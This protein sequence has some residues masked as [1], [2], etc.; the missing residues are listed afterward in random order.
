MDEDYIVILGNI[1]PRKSHLELAKAVDYINNSLNKAVNLVIVGSPIHKTT[2]ITKDIKKILGSRVIFTGYLKDSVKNLLL[3]FTACHAYVSKF[4]GFGL[5]VVESIIDDIP[6]IFYR[7]T[8]V[9]ELIP[10]KEFEVNELEVKV[11]S[12]EY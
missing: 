8:S 7:N 10:N 12:N 3:A 6:S 1:E 5:P 11:L 2:Q 9:A 4:E